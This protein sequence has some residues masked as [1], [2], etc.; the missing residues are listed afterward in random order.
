MCLQAVLAGAA[1]AAA[2]QKKDTA[3]SGL[4]EA[5]LTPAQA[6]LLQGLKG[7]VVKITAHYHVNFGDCLKGIIMLILSQHLSQPACCV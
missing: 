3:T 5:L 7:P 1:P 6:D 4:N 2:A